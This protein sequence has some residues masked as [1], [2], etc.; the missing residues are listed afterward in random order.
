[1]LVFIPKIIF[2]EKSEGVKE[3]GLKK[4]KP[5]K[6]FRNIVIVKNVLTF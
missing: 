5:K 2:N 6:I 1:M 4:G 3:L